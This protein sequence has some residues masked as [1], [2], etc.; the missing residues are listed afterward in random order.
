M[1]IPVLETDVE[2]I[3]AIRE[4]KEFNSSVLSGT[5]REL[6]YELSH[7]G[8]LIAFWCSHGDLYVNMDPSQAHLASN[9]EKLGPVAATNFSRGDDCIHQALFPILGPETVALLG[10]AHFSIAATIHE[11]EQDKFIDQNIKDRG[12]SAKFLQL[13]L[14]VLLK[15]GGSE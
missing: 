7:D 4:K 10:A 11:L 12:L 9:L 3:A 5:P 14:A 15:T 6:A 1:T 13:A 8:E 2:I